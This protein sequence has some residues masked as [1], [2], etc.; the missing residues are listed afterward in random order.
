MALAFHPKPGLVLICDYS[1]GF[2]GNEMTKRRPAVVLSP[3]LRHRAD[4]CTVIPL[5]GTPPNR[6]CDYHC[7]VE[8]DPLLPSPWNSRTY[9]AKCDMLATVGFHRLD[10]IRGPKD[11][12]GKRKYIER[13][14]DIETLRSLKKGALCAIGLAGLTDYV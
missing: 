3:R 6:V 8:F 13:S 11:F 7:L 9:W 1:T 5:S 4:L 14:V 10:L 12:E 2:S